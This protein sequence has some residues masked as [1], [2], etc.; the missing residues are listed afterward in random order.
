[1]TSGVRE[2]SRGGPKFR[3][4][5]VTSQTSFAFAKTAWFCFTFLVSEEGAMA[6]W[7]P[8]RYASG[9]DA[10]HA[11]SDFNNTSIVT[12]QHF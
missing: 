8:P 1:M 2:S 9:Y 11:I 3:H 10:P 5:R 4:N 7:P 6:Q 12:S